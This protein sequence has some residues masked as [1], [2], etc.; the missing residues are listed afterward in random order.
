NQSQTQ[1]HYNFGD[2]VSWVRGSHVFRFGGEYTRVNLDK[3][4]P[5]VF[6]GELFFTNTQDGNSDF[7]NFLLGTPQFSF[8]GGGVFNHEYRSNNFGFYTQDDWKIRHD[9]T[10]NLGVRAEMFRAF[11]GN[12]CHIGNL[13]PNLANQ[14]NFPFIYPSCVNHLNLAG[15]SGN[16]NGT[17]FRNNYSTTVGPR[18]GLAYDLFG[19]HTTTIRAG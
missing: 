10:L 6:N 7:Q 15:L 5:Q 2:P 18:L 17:T 1:N 11:N 3:L 16:A 8:G 14:G 9:L 13:D 4:F 12:L 19:R